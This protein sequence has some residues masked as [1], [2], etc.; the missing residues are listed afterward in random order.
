MDDL[1]A[2]V[3]PWIGAIA[4]AL[5]VLVL[6]L[7]V[8]VVVLLRR[9]SRFERRL[10]GLTR[11][12][13][14]QSLESILDAH[15]EQVHALA[16]E[17]DDLAARSAVLEA[18]QRKAF[19]RIGLVR[20]NPFEDTGGNQSFALALLDE[21]RRRVRGQQP[22]R[23]RRNARLRQGDHEGHVGGQPVRGG[24]RGASHRARHRDGQ[25][26]LTTM[27]AVT[28]K[29]ARARGTIAACP[30]S[31]ARQSPRRPRIQPLPQPAL[32][33]SDGRA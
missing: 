14:G 12:A 20:F 11:G 18:T 3:N 27:R 32:R 8:L 23:P 33:R 29:L 17:V 6:V 21:Q 7:L 10:A 13:D 15:L 24:G 1:N 2:L 30:L 22:P 4:I 9:T 19:Q 31:D 26:R 5:A 28:P 25:G 16:R